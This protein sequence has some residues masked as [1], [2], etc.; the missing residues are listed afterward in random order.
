[1]KSF[2][3][4]TISHYSQIHTFTWNTQTRK[5]YNAVLFITDKITRSRNTCMIRTGSLYDPYWFS[6]KY[7][8]GTNICRPDYN[9]TKHNLG[10]RNFFLCSCYEFN[11]KEVKYQ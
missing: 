8:M 11:E 3:K 10:N 1:M 2:K 5:Q 4:H 6:D 9:Y 7:L